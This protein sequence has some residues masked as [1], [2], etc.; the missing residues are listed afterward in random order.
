MSLLR[1]MHN[2]SG[3]CI[4]CKLPFF[5]R[6]GIPISFK[7]QISCAN[8]SAD[9][10]LSLSMNVGDVRVCAGLAEVYIHFYIHIIL[11]V[12]VYTACMSKQNILSFKINFYYM[13][14]SNPCC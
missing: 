3:R 5:C 8:S 10:F 1:W 14:V 13:K 11:F 6:S 9:E 2:K 4:L 12:L 7:K